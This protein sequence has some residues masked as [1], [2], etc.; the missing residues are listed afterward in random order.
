MRALFRKL[1]RARFA[2]EPL[3]SVRVNRRYLEHNFAEFSRLLGEHSVVPVLKSNAYG[4]GLVPVAAIFARLNP[5]FMVVDS[6][7]EALVLRNERVRTPL[8]VLGY[9]SAQNIARRRFVDVS[10]A[11][12]GIEQV[13]EVA[14]ALTAPQEFHLKIDTGMHRQGILVSELEQVIKLI[15]GN[16]NIKITRACTHLADSDGPDPEFSRMQ[17]KVW[18]RTVERLRAVFPDIKHVHVANSAGTQFAKEI[19]AHISRVGIGLYGIDP[20]N[21]AGKLDL[22]PALELVTQITSVR[23]IAPGEH[24][25]YNT[26]FT[27]KRPTQVATIPIGYFEGLDRRLSGVGSVLVRGQACPLI[28]RI[29]M[30]IS[31]IDVTDLPEA[32]AGDEVVVFSQKP[33]DP[34]SIE[35]AAKLAGTIPYDLLVHVAQHLRR[36]IVA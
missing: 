34:N 25:G 24:V 19:D 30:N 4:H 11:L 33:S 20:A 31:S 10:F 35:N 12:I 13:R 21:R 26:T 27:A 6:F 1:R 28:G 3:I 5:P 9:T 16:P 23:T 22:R 8:L 17:I 29:S 32:K 2:Y 15:K 36:T 18:N 7:Y 14:A